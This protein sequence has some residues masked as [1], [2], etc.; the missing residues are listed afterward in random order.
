MRWLVVDEGQHAL[1]GVGLAL[2]PGP[3]EM[4]DLATVPTAW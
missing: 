4:R 3:K 2:A 1:E